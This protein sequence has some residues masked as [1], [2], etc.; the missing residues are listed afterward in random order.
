MRILKTAAFDTVHGADIAQT[1]K[2]HTYLEL[3]S[4]R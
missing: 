1:S 4:N 2:Q 3:I